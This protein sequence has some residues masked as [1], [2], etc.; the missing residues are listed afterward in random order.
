MYIFGLRL[1][2]EYLADSTKTYIFSQSIFMA[3]WAMVMRA[4]A[5]APKNK[6]KEEDEFPF[7]L[8]CLGDV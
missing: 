4:N 1:C 7:R 3:G 8:L 5:P 6:K 2:G